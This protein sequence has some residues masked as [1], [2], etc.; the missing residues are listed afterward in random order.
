MKKILFIVAMLFI[1]FFTFAS[2]NSEDNMLSTPLTIEFP[3]D[4]NGGVITISNPHNMWY[5]INDGSKKW[6]TST[7]CTI[8]AKAGNRVSL[9][10][11]R[12]YYNISSVNYLHVD[13]SSDCYIYGNV[14]SL[15]EGE[16]FEKSTKVPEYAFIK[17]FMGNVK[18]QNHSTK[19]IVLPATT[20]EDNCYESM[21]AGCRG[22]TRGPLELP[23]TVMAYECYLSMF[24]D[25]INLVEAPKL[26]A[27]VLAYGC[28]KDMFYGCISLKEAPRL[29]ATSLTD[30]CYY[31]MFYGCTNLNSISCL[32]S[33]IPDYYCLDYWVYNV[34]KKG[35]FIK[36]EDVV[37][38][39]GN[40]GIPMDWIVKEI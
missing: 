25:C 21:F 1:A 38:P 14:M 2:D 18:I 35:T 4:G 6:V 20:L 32:A 5:S 33:Y 24:K 40:S 12:D 27:K 11:D 26:S 23:A 7:N 3:A 17:L 13:C 22:L 10:A 19:D 36:S 8:T 39:S 31:R 34:S 30:F 15:I 37:W 16:D 9:Y 29:L 28:C